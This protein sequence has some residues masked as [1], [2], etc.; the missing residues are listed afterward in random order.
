MKPLIKRRASSVPIHPRNRGS[1]PFTIFFQVTNNGLQEK[2]RKKRILERDSKL[3][4]NTTQPKIKNVLIGLFKGRWWSLFVVVVR[5]QSVETVNS[6]FSVRR[7][8]RCFEERAAEISK[9]VSNV[10]LKHPKSYHV[11]RINW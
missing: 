6:H 11:F 9:S 7:H 3:H 2:K 1:P 10:N 8:H 5:D 4:V